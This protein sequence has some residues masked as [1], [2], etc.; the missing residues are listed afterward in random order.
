MS[1][2]TT[3]KLEELAG[4]WN[5]DVAHSGVEFVARH[6]MIT[7]VRGRFDDFAATIELAP[8]VT[9]SKVTAT[10]KTASISTNS[11]DRDAHLRSGDF[12]DVEKHPELTFASTRLEP[13]SDSKAKLHGDLMVRGVTRP[14]VLDVELED[15]I[16]KDPWGAERLSFTAATRISRKEWDLTWNVALEAGG[17]LVSDEVKVDL[18]IVA[19]RQ[20]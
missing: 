7:N 4:T 9:D 15:H 12:L 5:V 16:A 20:Q 18:A 3:P 13:V 17:V 1:T 11:A 19:T 10:I 2:T 8:N 14:V 6:M